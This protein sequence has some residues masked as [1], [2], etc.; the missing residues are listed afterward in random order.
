MNL[1]DFK[2][3]IEKFDKIETLRGEIYWRC[4]NLID[5]NLKLGED[6]VESRLDAY[7]LL[8]SSWNV[9]NFRRFINEDFNNF[10]KAITFSEKYFSKFDNKDFENIDFEE[11]RKYIVAIFNKLSSVKGIMYTGASKIMHLRNPKVFLMW[12]TKIR[13]KTWYTIKGEDG[14]AYVDFLKKIQNSFSKS[15]R[16]IDKM[17][18]E[19]KN[20]NKTITKAIDEYNYITITKN[21]K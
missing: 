21:K 2:A 16:D 17:L 7:L 8:L 11:H 18:L 14:D 19:G 12:D 3:S 6:Q 4:L 20:K 1:E 15:F 9:A 5:K 13:R 10:K